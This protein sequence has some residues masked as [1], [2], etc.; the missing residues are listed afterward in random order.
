MGTHQFTLTRFVHF[1]F[2]LQRNFT[3]S[4]LMSTL[5]LRSTPPGQGVDTRTPA[6]RGGVGTRGKGKRW[7]VIA[8]GVTG[9][10]QDLVKTSLARDLPGQKN[11]IVPCDRI[12]NFRFRFSQLGIFQWFRAFTRRQNSLTRKNP[13]YPKK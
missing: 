2:P 9:H 11:W 12:K 10:V 8:P 13:N 7:L 3:C 5:S 4:H 6:T 1:P